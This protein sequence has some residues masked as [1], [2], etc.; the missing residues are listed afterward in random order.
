M[1]VVVV[2][3]GAGT[4]IPT[5]RLTAERET[6]SFPNATLIRINLDD[7]KV[8][9]AKLIDRAVSIGGLGALEAITLIDAQLQQFKQLRPKASASM[10]AVAGPGK[11]RGASPPAAP[12]A[13]ASPSV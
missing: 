3:V 5:M 9:N 7:C 11:Q 8:D 10:G 6:E 2:E 4:T 13:K 12:K 1:G